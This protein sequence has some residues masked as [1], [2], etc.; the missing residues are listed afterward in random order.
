[1]DDME[2]C[3][4]TSLPLLAHVIFC[5]LFHDFWELLPYPSREVHA[6]GLDEN[7]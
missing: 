7:F 5:W 2:G 3:I 6:W 1:M 4:Y